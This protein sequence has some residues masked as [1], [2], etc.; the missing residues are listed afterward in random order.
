MSASRPK[1]ALALY[2][3]HTVER[4]LA[5]FSEQIDPEAVRASREF[6]LRHWAAMAERAIQADH[7]ET[8]YRGLLP[9]VENAIAEHPADDLPAE[10]QRSIMAD[11]AFM[12]GHLQAFREI[13]RVLRQGRPEDQK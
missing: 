4:R 8:Y 3:R 7:A 10:L 12:E 11:I 6:H 2:R 5:R 1:R 13:V 9:N